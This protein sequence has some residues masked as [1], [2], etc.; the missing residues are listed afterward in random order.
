MLTY[1][2]AG[3][4]ASPTRVY[5]FTLGYTLF[6]TNLLGL[7]VPLKVQWKLVLVFQ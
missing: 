4:S 3:V 1:Y 2:K 5:S 6:D 7:Q